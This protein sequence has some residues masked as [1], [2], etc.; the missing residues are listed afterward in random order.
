MIYNFKSAKPHEDDNIVHHFESSS[1]QD[2][3]EPVYNDKGKK[4]SERVVKKVITKVIPDSEFENLDLDCDLFSVENLK[5]AGVDLFK[6]APTPVKL[7]GGDLDS[8]AAA[9]DALDNFDYS[10][11]TEQDFNE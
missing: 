5:Q 9:V 4:V 6:Q 1:I 10:Q 2:M 7:F 11:L 3:K 8:R